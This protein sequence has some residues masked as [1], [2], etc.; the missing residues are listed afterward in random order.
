MDAGL[1]T[2]RSIAEQTSRDELIVSHLKYVKHILGKLLIDFP[3]SVD[4]ENL[5]AAGILGLVEA[6]NR[7]TPERGID[8]KTFAYQRIRGA[9]F[10]E[11]RRNCPLPQQVLKH[12]ALIRKAI[13]DLHE[14]VSAE[15]I[16][17]RTGLSTDDVETCL[18]AIRMTQPESWHDELE[19]NRSRNQRVELDADDRKQ[20]LIAAIEELPQQMR[21]VITLYHMDQLTLKQIGEVVDLSESRVSR[22][23]ANAELKLKQRLTH[24]TDVALSHR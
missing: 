4:A 5:E 23:L 13:Q 11:L 10:D 16:S 14:N 6:A 1:K 2:Y 18:T 20:L 22:I 24:L 15:A 19:S 21:E 3:T 8:F 9:V 7:F 12:W 17:Q